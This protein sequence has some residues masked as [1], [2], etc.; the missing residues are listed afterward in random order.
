ML[1]VD[2]LVK[3]FGGLKAVD[4]LSFE[5]KKG[6]ILGIIGPNGAGKSVTFEMISGFYP[7][8]RGRVFLNGDCITGLQPHQILRYGLARSFQGTQI[9]PEFNP[10][11]TVLVAAL[12]S[13]PMKKARQRAEE[14]LEF[15]GLVGKKD[16]P[17]TSLTLPEL[18][19]VELGKVIASDPRILLLDE[20]MAGLTQTDEIANI[21]SG[22]RDEGRTLLIVE[23]R[24]D[25]LTSLCDR[26]IALNFGKKITE[27]T[28][29]QVMTHPEVIEA[30]LGKE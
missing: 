9:F 3:N 27:G 12:C 1:Q 11:Q 20:I 19:L 21:L 26:I 5:V 6:E 15:L 22:L 7:P 23:H 4:N 10:Y 24:I 2:G 29:Q 30:Y 8:T 18:K 28:P 25:A 14:I 17:I 16:W 13:L